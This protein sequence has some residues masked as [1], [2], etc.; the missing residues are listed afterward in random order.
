MEPRDRESRDLDKQKIYA[1]GVRALVEANA[2]FL[3]GGGFALYS[4]LGRWRT[5]K[6]VDLFIQADDLHTVLHILMRAGFQCEI[7]DTAWLAKARKADA[8]IDIIFCSYNGLFP[9]DKG[10][11]ENARRAM[12]LGLPV[13]IVGPEEIIASKSFVAARDRFDGADISWLIRATAL[14]L[15]WS[16][17]EGL[18]RDHWQVL[19]WQL[20]HFLYVFPSE[21]HLLPT[22]LMGRLIGALGNEITADDYEPLVCRGPMLDP[23]LYQ[24]EI[25]VRGAADPRPRKN[26]VPE[27]AP[28]LA[29]EELEAELVEEPPPAELVAEGS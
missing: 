5:T 4:Y 21:R 9:V 2:P 1:E 26:L 10:W 12:V 14:K 22:A 13:K 23:R 3:V 19:L 18:M 29:D 24:A 28:Y 15:D 7:T 17:I 16:R 25:V 20:L 6:D 8:C 27:D 11:F